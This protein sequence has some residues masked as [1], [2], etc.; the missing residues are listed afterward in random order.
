MRLFHRKA[1]ALVVALGFGATA[2][3][4]GPVAK[5]PLVPGS[6]EWARWIIHHGHHGK[7]WDHDVD[8]WMRHHRHRHLHHHHN[9]HDADDHFAHPDLGGKGAK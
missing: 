2:W 5:T 6:N 3:A 4:G 9:D 7:D 1:A 8:H